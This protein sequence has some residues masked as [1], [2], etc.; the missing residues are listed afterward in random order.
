MSPKFLFNNSLPKQIS[1][2][3]SIVPAFRL[4]IA[5]WAVALIAKYLLSIGTN[6]L[7]FYALQPIVFA[8]PIAI[9]AYRF[10]KPNPQIL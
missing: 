10:L 1:V 6:T 4:I 8:L 5:L 2:W 7:P 9:V 3:A